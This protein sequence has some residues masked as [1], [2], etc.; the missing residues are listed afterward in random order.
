LGTYTGAPPSM[1]TTSGESRL[2]VK[3]EYDRVVDWR[4]TAKAKGRIKNAFLVQPATALLAVSFHSW[5]HP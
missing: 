5:Y 1:M 4:L 3:Y 2:K